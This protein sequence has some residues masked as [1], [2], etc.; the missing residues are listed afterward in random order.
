MSG[1]SN[2]SRFCLIL[3]GISSGKSLFSEQVIGRR[4]EESDCDFYYFTPAENPRDD[5]MRAKVA[6]HRARRPDWLRT[7]ECGKLPAG[8][9]SGLNRGD[10]ILFDSAGTLAGRY[11]MDQPDGAGCMQAVADLIETARLK[12][13]NI[14]FVSEEVGMS[15]VSLSAAG[16]SF[17]RILGEL[18][19][20]LAAES[21]EVY[22]VVAGI[23]RKIK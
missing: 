1:G 7:V 23:P 15:L 14:V 9:L 12:Q 10:T 13:L 6:A 11:I 21:D 5:E 8:E 18:N 4:H 19:Q 17:Q 3:G 2:E 20:F 16:R 22:Y